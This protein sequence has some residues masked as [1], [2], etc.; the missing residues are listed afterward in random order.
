MFSRIRKRPDTFQTQQ[1]KN[2]MNAAAKKAAAKKAA[3]KKRVPS[4]VQQ[5]KG[6]RK[7]VKK[8]VAKKTRTNQEVIKS[9]IFTVVR[10]IRNKETNNKSR[11]AY[12][13]LGSLYRDISSVQLKPYYELQ[14][15]DLIKF[16]KKQHAALTKSSSIK[17]GTNSNIVNIPMDDTK[18]QDF[19]LMLWLDMA[20]DKII[21]DKLSFN[22]YLKSNIVKLFY[23]KDIKIRK[24]E[25]LEEYINANVVRDTQG[26]YTRL[27][28]ADANMVTHF[29]SRRVNSVLNVPKTQSIQKRII[30]RYKPIYVSFD[31]EN[32]HY[33]SD[34]IK[35]S[36]L[37]NINA[38][39]E[40]VR[41]YYLKRIY[42]IAN[43]MDPGRGASKNVGGYG[44][45][46]G[47]ID[48]LISRIFEKEPYSPFKHN[49]QLFEFKFGNYF[50]LKI[51]PSEGESKFN[52][53]IT[54][55]ENANTLIRT[56]VKR[57]NANTIEQK[58]SKTFGDLMQI[59][60]VAH[61]RKN[62]HNVVSS[63]Q[64]RA[65]IGV[66]GFVQQDL[67]G[68]NPAIITENS[69]MGAKGAIGLY[70]L[71]N[72]IKSN[73]TPTR[74]TGTTFIPNNKKNNNKN[75]N[76]TS[77]RSNNSNRTVVAEPQNNN[78]LGTRI[79]A[80]QNPVINPKRPRNNNGTN[81]RRVTRS[82]K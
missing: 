28:A 65:F 27:S 37:N 24:T 29:K 61:L 32:A 36:V 22:A 52:V 55:N 3:V 7:P 30:N 51:V 80:P 35:S 34:L 47:T 76:V 73:V 10:N 68:V 11:A 26:V 25:L 74:S 20:H 67:F 70:G 82:R 19:F 2:A 81:G 56:G 21:N 14:D 31:A 8:P 38:R 43:L 1:E 45:A 64:D 13:F 58:L 5:L 18:L 46:G 15:E 71:K 9:K 23:K 77:V 75:N 42:T 16:M 62:N 6:V 17:V 4:K 78:N 57:T 48:E 63:T 39:G 41:T 72:Y 40:P 44:K 54:N 79:T 50:T 53:A 59:L 49:Y 69:L 33:I 66:T 60:T 12:T